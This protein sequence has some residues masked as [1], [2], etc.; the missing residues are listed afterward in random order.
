MK[1]SSFCRRLGGLCLLLVWVQV[2]TANALPC[3]I[4]C[5]LAEQVAHHDHAGL[6]EDHAIGHHIAGAKISAPE[7]C[8]TPQLLVVAA[9][10]PDFPTLPAVAVAVTQVAL[11]APLPVISSTPEFDTPPP[12]A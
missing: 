6:G 4:E 9:D 12:R 11:A 8:G 7:Y 10:W 3:G 1:T 2:A 5:F